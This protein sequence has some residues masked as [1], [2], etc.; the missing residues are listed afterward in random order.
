MADEKKTPNP[1]RD[2]YRNLND[3]EV[4][5]ISEIKAAAFNLYEKFG[6]GSTAPIYVEMGADAKAEQRI[7]QVDPRMMA[8]AKTSLEQAVMWAVKSITG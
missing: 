8:L 7:V 2:E 6:T 3:V 4:K 1:F 5:A